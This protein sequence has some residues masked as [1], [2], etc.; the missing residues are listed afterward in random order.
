[1]M[2]RQGNLMEVVAALQAIGG[3]AYLLH[4]WHRQCDEDSDNGHYHEQF[5]QGYAPSTFQKLAIFHGFPLGGKEGPRELDQN[6]SRIRNRFPLE[7]TGLWTEKVPSTCSL[8]P[9]FSEVRL[10]WPRPL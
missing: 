5:N 6:G 4:R 9:G 10:P 7:K 8:I 2:D 3:L 1:M